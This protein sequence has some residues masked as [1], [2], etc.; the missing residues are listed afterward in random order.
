MYQRL[1]PLVLGHV[2]FTV[3]CAVSAYVTQTHSVWALLTTFIWSHGATF[4]LLGMYLGDRSD[5]LTDARLL[6]ARPWII[7]L[8]LVSIFGLAYM[9]LTGAAVI[10]CH[11]AVTSTPFLFIDP[12]AS[13]VRDE[14][15]TR[16]PTVALFL[17]L[18][19][20]VF[21]LHLITIIWASVQV[22]RSNVYKASL[23][24]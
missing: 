16:E 22:R 6:E 2:V 10:T 20:L 1:L 19:C 15:T 12:Y 9:G 11:P 5:D 3:I 23:R 18:V 17:S 21:L 13:E 14:W 4:F 8:L 24:V 7:C